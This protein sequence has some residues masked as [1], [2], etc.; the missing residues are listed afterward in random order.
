VV[1]HVAGMGKGYTILVRK[2]E[3]LRLLE[4]RKH[5]WQSNV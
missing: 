4:N 5:R 2:S 3:R 1:G